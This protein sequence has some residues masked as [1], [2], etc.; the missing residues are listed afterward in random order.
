MSG[1]GELVLASGNRHKLSERQKLLAPRQVIVR[2]QNEFGVESVE[3]T[4]KT[5]V[6]NSVLKARHAAKQTARWALA[7]DS[8]IVVEALDGAPG[9]YSAR[10]AG[11]NAS[12]EENNLKLIQ[13]LSAHPKPWRAYYVAALALVSPNERVEPIVAC[14]QWHGEIISTPRGSRGFGYD[15]YFV[16]TG[17]VRTAAEMESEEKNRCSHRAVALQ[18]L[19]RL[20]PEQFWHNY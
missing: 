10:Y 1:L 5:F 16:P 14:G 12:D 7:D 3:E 2:A 20:W 6:G 17:E 15:P 18:E 13:A 4:E 9:V 19:L 11:L 8:G